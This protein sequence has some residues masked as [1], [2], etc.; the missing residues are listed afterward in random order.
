VAQREWLEQFL[1]R[2]A[3]VL[4]NE[5]DLREEWFLQF[6]S[7]YAHLLNRFTE[8]ANKYYPMTGVTLAPGTDT[9]RH[10]TF[11]D[12]EKAVEENTRSGE[13]VDVNRWMSDHA[14]WFARKIPK[15]SETTSLVMGV[16]LLSNS[17]TTLKPAGGSFLNDPV[18]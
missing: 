13:P 12:V 6:K 14:H 8:R 17:R 16:C 18:L 7:L 4:K 11:E 15:S 10:A 1:R 5:Y 3:D 9:Y 2:F